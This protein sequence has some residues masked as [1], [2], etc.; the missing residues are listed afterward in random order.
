M[1]ISGAR[2]NHTV[3]VLIPEAGQYEPAPAFVSY[4][5]SKE[6]P[7]LLAQALV[8]DDAERYYVLTP[9]QYRQV[10]DNH[11]VDYVLIAFVSLVLVFAPY[12]FYKQNIKLANEKQN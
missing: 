5:V 6:N 10:T 11:F 9:K 4:Q 2:F 1:F 12:L 3:S 7:N 8:N